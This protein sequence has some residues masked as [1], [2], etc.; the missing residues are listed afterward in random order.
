MTDEPEPRDASIYKAA[1]STR[2]AWA[3]ALI[4]AGVLL[5]ATVVAAVS[6]GAG[7]LT[8]ALLGAT[9]VVALIGGVLALTRVRFR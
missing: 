9:V 3:N 2:P 5:V 1:R 6:A 7:A 8:W 4:V